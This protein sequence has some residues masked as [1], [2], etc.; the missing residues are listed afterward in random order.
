MEELVNW[1]IEIYS[2]NDYLAGELD[3]P[4][5]RENFWDKQIQ[6][7]QKEL[8]KYGC[9]YHA[10]YWA[11][12]DNYNWEMNHTKNLKELEK[13][14]Y[15]YGYIDWVWM[16]LYKGV[17]MIRNWWNKKRPDNQIITYRVEIW[18][19]KFYEVLAKWYSVHTGFKGNKKLNK[20]KLDWVLDGVE[21][22]SLTYGHSIRDSE[23]EK[24]FRIDNYNYKENNIYEVKDIKGL[25]KNWV[26]F[27]YWY[28]Y[29]FKNDMKTQLEKDIQSVE[30]ALELWITNNEQ[31]LIDVKK[32]N[33]TE[34]NKTTIKVM[35]MYNLL[36]K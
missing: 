35:R 14:K 7:N 6:F 28:I 5:A 11:V 32:G 13:I 26:N 8:D 36:K 15:N 20:D 25:V 2:Q 21:F 1:A 23:K 9:I 24:L 34:S 29:I 19:E 16:Y 30:E 12:N 31:E 33:Y 27:K 4:K 3:I 10:W 17:D 18:S 22:G